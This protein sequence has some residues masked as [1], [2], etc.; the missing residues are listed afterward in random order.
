MFEWMY[1]FLILMSFINLVM[2][3]SWIVQFLL[4]GL[5]YLH[6]IHM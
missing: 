2:R 1:M 5:R 4:K 3:Y 6:K